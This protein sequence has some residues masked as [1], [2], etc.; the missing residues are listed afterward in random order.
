MCNR[1]AL[2]ACRIGDRNKFLFLK[3]L[4]PESLFYL[5]AGMGEKRNSL[6]VLCTQAEKGFLQSGWWP[7]ILEVNR[8]NWTKVKLGMP[9]IN[10]CT[11]TRSNQRVHILA[12]WFSHLSAHLLT[13]VGNL[14]SLTGDLL[15]RHIS[16]RCNLWS[17]FLFPR[18]QL[19]TRSCPR[20]SQG[21]SDLQPFTLF[22]HITPVW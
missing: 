15:S 5:Q 9:E 14:I 8:G 22:D 13:Q 21:S 4:T 18:S 3:T 6:V 10:L 16:Q 17:L 11:Q 2:W 19:K 12:Q 1:R 7:Y 20:S